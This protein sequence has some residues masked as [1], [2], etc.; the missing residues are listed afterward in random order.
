MSENLRF[1]Y[2]DVMGLDANWRNFLTNTFVRGH[3][4]V[5]GMLSVGHFY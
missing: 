3:F 2:D 1:R 4:V 5:L